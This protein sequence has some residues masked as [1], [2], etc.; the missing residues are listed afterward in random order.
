MHDDPFTPETG[1][2]RTREPGPDPTHEHTPDGD[3]VG[4]AWEDPRADGGR[5]AIYFRTARAVLL[6]PQQTFRSMTRSPSIGAPLLFW[7]ASMGLSVLLSALINVAMGSMLRGFLASLSDLPTT[8]GAAAVGPV[9][10]VVC[11]SARAAPVFFI[12]AGYYHLL[13]NMFGVARHGFSATFRTMAYANGSLSLVAWVPCLGLVASLLYGPY[14]IVVGFREAH[15]STTGR[16][17]LA[18]LVGMVVP[19][20]LIGGALIYLALSGAGL[21]DKIPIPM[22]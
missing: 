18:F 19:A 8:P 9:V 6:E 10:T 1:D 11:V 7:V 20:I 4:P 21:T 3:R 2:P 22:V 15:E 13:L 12:T 16:V 5:V 17:T 14:L